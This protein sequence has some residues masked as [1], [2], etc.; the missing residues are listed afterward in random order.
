L[1]VRVN[2][3]EKNASNIKFTGEFRT[4]FDRLESSVVNAGNHDLKG[5][6]RVNA[7]AQ[8]NEDW[9]AGIRW[10]NE[11]SLN[12]DT[13]L[14]GVYNRVTRAYVTGPVA[15]TK[16][17][18]GTFG[19][20]SGT[21]LIFDD[22]LSGAKVEFGNLLKV[23]LLVANADTNV[24]ALNDSTAFKAK[25][26]EVQMNYDLSKAT[27]AV[28]SYQKW[29]DKNNTVEAIKAWDLGLSTKFATDYSLYG[30][31]GKS[32]EAQNNK[33][34][35]VGVSYK[36]AD[37][38]KQGSYGM[39]LNYEN[40]KGNL[41]GTDNTYNIS[42]NKKGYVVGFN[43]VPAKNILFGLRYMDYKTQANANAADN[44]IKGKALRAQA[45][46]FF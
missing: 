15:G 3:L 35:V 2:K 39:Y 26:S 45:E 12:N 27:S 32:T 24:S 13:E 6:L 31:Y 17:T 30:S 28:A 4:R 42:G 38:N 5:L 41:F 19:E 1:N 7:V 14:A 36:G 11:R 9:T 37:Q 33:A 16:L 18:V 23:K 29:E 10:E 34:Y 43:Y 44:D 20:V 22:N 40:M 46:F 8:I 21:G 25:L